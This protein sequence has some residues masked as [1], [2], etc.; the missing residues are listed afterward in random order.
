MC[1]DKGP[2]I[3]VGRVKETEEILGGYNPLSWSTSK[4]GFLSTRKSFIFS[5]DKDDVIEKNIISF[6]KDERRAIYDVQD[7]LPNF[8]GGALLFG[9]YSGKGIFTNPIALDSTRYKNPIRSTSDRFTWI[10]WE[11]FSVD[12]LIV[13]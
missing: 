13:H 3:S 12:K 6:V 2:T 11:V 1:A 7:D 9:Y 5:L 8:G 4:S 10:D